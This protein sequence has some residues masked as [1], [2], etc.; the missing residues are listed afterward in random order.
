M[1]QKLWL[2]ALLCSSALFLA[3]CQKPQEAAKKYAMGDPVRVGQ[4]TYSVVESEWKT[5][6]GESFKVRSPE[7][8]FLLIKISI[9]NGTGK[10]ASIPLFTLEASNGQTYRELSDGEGV[11]N[12]FGLLRTL[13]PGQTQQGAILFDAPLTSFKLRIPDIA[14]PGLERYVTVDIPLRLDSDLPIQSPISPDSL[15]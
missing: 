4:M 10:D 11:V 12:W 6:L 2:C 5:Q 1:T 14:D 13:S 9:T 15:K 8:R 7:N 3:S